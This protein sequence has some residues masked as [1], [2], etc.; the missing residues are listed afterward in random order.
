MPWKNQ[1]HKASKSN[2]GAT[3]S[4]ACRCRAVDC[5]PGL[6]F[7]RVRLPPR[8]ASKAEIDHPRDGN[9]LPGKDLQREQI[10]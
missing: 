1:S 10:N 2:K 3:I 7:F 6:A 9:R 8:Y 5:A 4:T